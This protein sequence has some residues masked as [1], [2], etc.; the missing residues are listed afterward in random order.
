M[1]WGRSRKRWIRARYVAERHVIESSYEKWEI[2]G[3]PEI[4]SRGGHY[5]SF[6][7][8]RKPTAQLSPVEEPPPI[9][10]QLERFLVLLFL[11]RYV[12]WCARTGR[13]SRRSKRRGC[14][15][16]S[17]RR[18]PDF[19][20]DQMTC[21]YEHN[22]DR[23]QQH[24]FEDEIQTIID[25]A[26]ESERVCEL[27]S[28]LQKTLAGV[29]A[30]DVITNG[31]GEERIHDIAAGVAEYIVQVHAQLEKQADEDADRQ[32]SH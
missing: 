32:G 25:R 12:T 30:A 2:T 19:E 11:R 21:T 23:E 15:G 8:F 4:R 1:R 31:G 6:N 3:P 24:R 29:I 20:E 26:Y 18:G 14:G 10:D 27:A 16:T 28:A 5:D 7:P 17:R 13:L 9:E 22:H